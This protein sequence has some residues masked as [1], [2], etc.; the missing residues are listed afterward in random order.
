M[1]LPEAGADNNGYCRHQK[2]GA[3]QRVQ[4][5]CQ[6]AVRHRGAEGGE[7]SLPVV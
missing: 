5:E 3:E 6:R 1:L 4:G 2:Q 7:D